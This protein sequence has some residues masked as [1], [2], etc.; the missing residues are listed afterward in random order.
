MKDL[1]ANIRM[2]FY[3]RKMFIYFEKQVDLV[4]DTEQ[5]DNNFNSRDELRLTMAKD[6]GDILYNRLSWNNIIH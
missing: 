1:I 4:W 6:L 3:L 5:Y 2:E